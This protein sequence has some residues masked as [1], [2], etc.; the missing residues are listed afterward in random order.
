MFT[1]KLVLNTTTSFQHWYNICIWYVCSETVQNI[2]V[3]RFLYKAYTIQKFIYDFLCFVILFDQ[4]MFLKKISSFGKV[5][6][7]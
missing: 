6:D 4:K 3:E 7:W 1:A 2:D 5:T